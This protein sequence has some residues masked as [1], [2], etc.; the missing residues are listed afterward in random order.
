MG[1]PCLNGTCP[2]GGT[3]LPG[4]RRAFPSRQ[5]E[6]GAGYKNPTPHIYRHKAP[7]DK[8]AD[9]RYNRGWHSNILLCGRNGS[10]IGAR[11]VGSILRPAF[12]LPR[13]HY[14]TPFTRKV[15]AVF[16]CCQ[17]GAAACWL[18]GGSI[19]CFLIS[20][21][22]LPRVPVC[23]TGAPGD[24]R[25]PAGKTGRKDAPKDASQRQLF[26]LRRQN[27]FNTAKKR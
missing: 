11:G 12:Y 18:M 8:T 10:R 27:F 13:C 2:G 23:R 17:S 24:I 25:R 3:F 6:S 19:G 26:C 20:T 1:V 15:Q 9:F 16:F 21:R 22:F 5:T 7:L 4:P 14:S